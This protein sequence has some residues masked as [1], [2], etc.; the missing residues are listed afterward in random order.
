MSRLLL[1]N[2]PR[3]HPQEERKDAGFLSY[4]D[5]LPVNQVVV[6]DTDRQG[7]EAKLSVGPLR[8]QGDNFYKPGPQPAGKDKAMTVS[9]RRFSTDG[10]SAVR[11]QTSVVLHAFPTLLHKEDPV[12]PL[13]LQQESCPTSA[14]TTS[15][16]ASRST[17]RLLFTS[18]NPFPKS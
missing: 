17:P 12:S 3:D 4:K 5:H 14:F 11:V 9:P 1:S 7:S 8:C 15:L 2:A 16:L 18:D 6:G 13:S 10:T